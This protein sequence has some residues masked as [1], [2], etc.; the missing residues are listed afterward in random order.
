[1]SATHLVAVVAIIAMATVVQGVSGFGFSL[2]SM[3]LL[4]ALL[5]VKQALAIQ[6]TLGI[7]SNAATASRARSDV[8][9]PD[10]MSYVVP[11]RSCLPPWSRACRSGGS[12][13]TTSAAETSSSSWGSSSA[14]WRSTWH[15]M[16]AYERRAPAWTT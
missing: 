1:M 3:P 15:C 16:C 12:C 10:P 9:A 5:G 7:A 14:S 4:A 6:P 13:S 11:R 8:R 2:A